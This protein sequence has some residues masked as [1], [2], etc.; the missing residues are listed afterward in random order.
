MM[1]ERAKRKLSAILSADVKGYSRMMG[2]DG[3]ILVWADRAEE[4][5][6]LIKKA[7]SLNPMFPPNYLWN[8]GHAFLLTERFDEAISTF[9]RAIAQNPDFWPSHILLAASYSAVGRV[10]EARAEATKTLRINPDFSLE[11]WRLKC[12]FKNKDVLERRFSMLR[13]AGLK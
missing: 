3:G 5:I 11:S 8:L 1:G 13:K 10:E 2:Q 9:K 12:P 4:A 6:E 7:M